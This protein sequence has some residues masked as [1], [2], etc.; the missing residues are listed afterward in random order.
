MILIQ[1]VGL[2]NSNISISKDCSNGALLGNGVCNDETNNAECNFDGGDCCGE[3]IN[4]TNC[5]Q[6][7]CHAEGA[8]TIDVSCKCN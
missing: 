4:T 3:C 2:T 8:P 6:C 1:F 7:V 5:S